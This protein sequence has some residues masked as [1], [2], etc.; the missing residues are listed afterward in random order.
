[1]TLSLGEGDRKCTPVNKYDPAISKGYPAGQPDLECLGG[2]V[3]AAAFAGTAHTHA[4]SV[5]IFPGEGDCLLI[6]FV[7]LFL[8][9]SSRSSHCS[10]VTK[11]DLRPVILGSIPTG[12][13]ISHW[14]RQEG[15]LAKIAPVRW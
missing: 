13:Q 8:D 15:H 14:W 4:I 1:M 12:T 9:C 6:L 3:K 2:S 5:A 11:V 7:H 10:V